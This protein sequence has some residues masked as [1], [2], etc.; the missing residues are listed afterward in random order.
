MKTKFVTKVTVIDKRSVCN[1]LCNN[2]KT[3]KR[4]EYLS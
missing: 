3:D 1:N 2:Y 4:I